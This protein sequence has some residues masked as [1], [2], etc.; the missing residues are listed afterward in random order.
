MVTVIQ[1][2]LFDQVGA[3]IGLRAVTLA[4]PVPPL[5]EAMYWHPQDTIN[6]AHQWLREQIRRLS[7]TL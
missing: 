3:A 7:A 1:R 5:H 6:A 2:R 4:L